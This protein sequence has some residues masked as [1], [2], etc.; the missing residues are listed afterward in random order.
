MLGIILFGAFDVR[1]DNDPIE[2]TFMEKRVLACFCLLYDHRLGTAAERE[3]IADTLGMNRKR[4]RRV[5]FDIK[6][7]LG[8]VSPAILPLLDDGDMDTAPDNRVKFEVDYLTFSG[9]LDTFFHLESMPEEA[10]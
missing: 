7:K 8:L 3:G 6:K 10:L 4:L 1:V 2:L 9:A 5:I